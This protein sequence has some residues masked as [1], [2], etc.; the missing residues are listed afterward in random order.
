LRLGHP[1][2]EPTGLRLAI[3]EW[4]AWH[5]FMLVRAV[6]EAVRVTARIGESADEIL[7]RLPAGI[8]A[9]AFHLNLTMTAAFPTDREALVHGLLARRIV[10]L[11]DA[12][13][14]ISKTWV[15][16]RCR[17]FGLPS[18]ATDVRGEASERVIVK[19]DLNFGGKSERQLPPAQPSAIG[20]PISDVMSDWTAY[21][22]MRREDVPAIWWN[23]PALVIERFIDNRA[24]HLYRVNF[25]GDRIVILRLTNP[26]PLKKIMN[27]TARRDV[28]CRTEDLATGAVAGV[29][30]SV[31]AVIVEYLARS[32]MDFGALEI[33]P[34]DAGRAYI[35]DVN[36]TCYAKVLNVGILTYLRGGLFGRIATR[37]AHLGCP[38][39]Q[40]RTLALPTWPML[41]GDARRLADQ[42]ISRVTRRPPSA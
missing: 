19:T 11:N 29:E 7:D 21:Q 14:D 25:A 17:A 13:T 34:D 3:Y 35:I 5:Q 18:P 42:L 39:P 12:V 37:A 36:S 20:P 22:V 40:S 6:P 27:S 8:N 28:Y 16:A 32:G 31:A 4:D 1:F 10:P 9:F 2:E 23:D 38:V 24:R 15:H 30:P 33:I 26:H 41:R